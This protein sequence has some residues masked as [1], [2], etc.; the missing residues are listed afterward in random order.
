MT[1]IGVEEG[2]T[3]IQQALSAQGYDVSQ[4]RHAADAA[5]VNYDFCV[6]TGL[7]TNVMGIQ[8]T[9]TKASII[10][11]NGLTADDIVSVIKSRLNQ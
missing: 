2:L 7:D 1:R 4:L 3:D 5:N 8:D 9:S 6:V 10:E 11:A